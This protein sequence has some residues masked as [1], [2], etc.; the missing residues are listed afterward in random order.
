MN[1]ME[2]T[3]AANDPAMGSNR[4]EEDY[5]VIYDDVRDEELEIAATGLLASGGS[6]GGWMT[7]TVQCCSPYDL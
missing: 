4:L 2:A 3:I 5:S 1:V 7:S 6:A